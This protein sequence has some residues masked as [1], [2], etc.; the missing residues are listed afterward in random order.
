MNVHASCP[1]CGKTIASGAQQVAK[2]VRCPH[3][4]SR[5]VVFADGSAREVNDEPADVPKARPRTGYS[6]RL[7]WAA[8]AVGHL[9]LGVGLAVALVAV[10]QLVLTAAAASDRES[11][12]AL[13][14]DVVSGVSVLLVGLAVGCVGLMVLLLREDRQLDNSNCGHP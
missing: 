10:V 11:S 5:V 4:G 1:S 3:C 12:T 7:G 14:A 8:G 13:Q 9:T 6:R 2:P